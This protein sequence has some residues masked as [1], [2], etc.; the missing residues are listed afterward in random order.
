VELLIAAIVG[1]SGILAPVLATWAI[2]SLCLHCQESDF[3]YC[4]T[5]YFG[6]MLSIGFL[7]VRTMLMHDPCWL[8]NASSLGVL[9]VGGALKG[10]H[11]DASSVLSGN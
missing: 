2:A 6:S 9:I 10:R 7:T 8:I 1:Y 4:Q 11:E 5:V 3:G